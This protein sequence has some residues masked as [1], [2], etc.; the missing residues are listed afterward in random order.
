M[1]SLLSTIVVFILV[2]GILVFVH[3]LGH[4]LAAKLFK[5]RVDEFCLGFPPRLIKI[6]RGDTLYGINLVPLGGYVKIKGEDGS[7]KGD[8]DSFASKPIWQRAIVLFAGVFMNFITAMVFISIGLMIGLPSDVSDVSAYNTKANIREVNLR[9]LS[10]KPESPAEEAGLKM[11]DIIVSL[12]DNKLTEVA[13]VQEYI[14]NNKDAKFNMLVKREN[15]LINVEITPKELDH[16]GYYGIGVDLGK[17]GLVSYPFH[18]AIWE[19]IKRTVFISIYIVKAFGKLLGSLV[20]GES[21]NIQVAGPL[22]IAEKTGEFSS[23]GFTF[24]LNFVA[25]LSINLC[26]LNLLPIPALDGAKLFLLI[27]EKIRGRAI[28]QK[29][30][31]II[32]FIGFAFLMLLMLIVT[33]KEII[34]YGKKAFDAIVKWF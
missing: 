6:K 2:L 14:K 5:I 31:N 25:M 1:Y 23:L 3:E 16:L 11:G 32:H 18:I 21:T 17:I 10:I 19:G 9:I 22:G 24:L 13:T 26:I 28:D 33:F 27:I 4:F 8:H 34:F 20:M 15:E 12:N 30:E 29:I 7:G